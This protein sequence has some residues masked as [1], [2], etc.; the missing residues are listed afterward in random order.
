MAARAREYYSDFRKPKNTPV[1]ERGAYGLALCYVIEA[2]A[3]KSDDLQSCRDLAN[4]AETLL[5]EGRQPEML[6]REELW[7][8][9]MARALQGK[10]AGAIDIL[11]GAIR[12]GENRV[13]R[14]EALK[15]LVFQGNDVSD[16]Q[17]ERLDAVCKKIPPLRF[18]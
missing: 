13:N 11:E 17:R 16:G 18:D 9:S 10:Y 5:L 6:P 15:Q 12:Q 14:I 1:A 3:I 8:L 7:T 4:S 2:T